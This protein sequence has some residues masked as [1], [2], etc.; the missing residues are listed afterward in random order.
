MPGGRYVRLVAEFS[1][2]CSSW[3]VTVLSVLIEFLLDV[4]GNTYQIVRQLVEKI[5]VK[6]LVRIFELVEVMYF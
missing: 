5:V 3:T 2:L 1:G 6:I 4:P